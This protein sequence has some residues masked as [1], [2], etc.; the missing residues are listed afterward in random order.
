MC[1][2]RGEE[3]MNTTRTHTNPQK[4]YQD[5]ATESLAA[6]SGRE[7]QGKT[8]ACPHPSPRS[9]APHLLALGP[10]PG[11]PWAPSAARQWGSLVSGF[12][13]RFEP[14]RARLPQDRPPPR[15][16]QGAGAQSESRAGSARS[17]RVSWSSNARSVIVRSAARLCPSQNSLVREQ[18]TCR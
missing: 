14:V 10:L 4:L 6:G 17:S 1:K 13:G 12:T 15:E 3:G 5:L 2:G 16:Y 18:P 9:W 7:K 8:Q 11:Q